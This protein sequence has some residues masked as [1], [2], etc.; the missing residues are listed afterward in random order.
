MKHDITD[1]TLCFIAQWESF[2]AHAYWDA[3]GKV[4]TVGYGHTRQV[5]KDTVCTKAKA[6]EWM[7]AD[8]AAIVRYLN[9]L[10]MNIT[11]QQFD[12]LVD[13]AFNVGLGNLRKSTLLRLVRHSAPKENVMAEFYKWNRSGGKV[14]QGL[15]IRREGDAML[16]GCGKYANWEEAKYHL[17][18]RTGR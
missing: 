10:D 8:C 16:Y 2:R 18:K 7:R 12:A 5:T 9:S 6:V 4:W 14:L 15:S 11:Q 17:E 13:F 3:S 1:N